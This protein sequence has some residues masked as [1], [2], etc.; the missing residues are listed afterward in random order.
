M[1]E[2]I[3]NAESH[4]NKTYVEQLCDYVIPNHDKF[5]KR[6]TSDKIE[7]NV[8]KEQIAKYQKIWFATFQNEVSDEVATENILKAR[9]DDIFSGS[10]RMSQRIGNK[11]LN[12][13]DYK[14]NN[15]I[16]FDYYDALSTE[17]GNESL[18]NSFREFWLFDSYLFAT[19]TFYDVVGTA[20]QDGEIDKVK[21]VID[22]AKIIADA[23]YNEYHE[24]EEYDDEDE[25]YDDEDED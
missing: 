15:P 1:G 25:E 19:G 2:P 24:D 17:E 8:T 7:S 5:Q 12:F 6:P 14:I 13:D 20:P 4:L 21:E 16:V 22:T 3:E 23:R 11:L 18:K 10:D 9:I